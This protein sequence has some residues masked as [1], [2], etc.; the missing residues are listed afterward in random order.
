MIIKVSNVSIN[1]L[2][3]G[4]MVP[5]ACRH[6]FIFASSFALRRHRHE[7]TSFAAEELANF[8]PGLSCCSSLHGF[9]VKTLIYGLK[10]RFYG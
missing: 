3:Y 2:D 1:P 8:A 9:Q 4:G 10:L 5:T 7:L 6:E